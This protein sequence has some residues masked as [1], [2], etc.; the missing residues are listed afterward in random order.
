MSVPKHYTLANLTKM[1]KKQMKQILRSI[2][3]KSEKE[4]DLCYFN[5][6]YRKMILE[7]QKKKECIQNFKQYIS[8]T[9]NIVPPEIIF[10][11]NSNKIIKKGNNKQFTKF[12]LYI[13]N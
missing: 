10:A 12:K 13:N 2:Y 9:Y 8:Q 5:D 11:K 3:G 7:L 6:P 4:I 1:N